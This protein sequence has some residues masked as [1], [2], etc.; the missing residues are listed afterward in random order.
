MSL[1]PAS[2]DG[3]GSSPTR[4]SPGAA[5][6]VDGAGRL[7]GVIT[8]ASELEC[9]P[10]D[11]NGDGTVD[12]RDIGC[13]PVGSALARLRPANLARVRDRARHRV[14]LQSC[15]PSAAPPCPGRHRHRRPR[16]PRSGLPPTEAKLDRIARACSSARRSRDWGWPRQSLSISV[17][18]RRHL[19]EPGGVPPFTRGRGRHFGSGRQCGIRHPGRDR[20]RRHHPARPEVCHRERPSFSSWVSSRGTGPRADLMVYSR[21]KGQTMTTDQA[22]SPVPPSPST[23]MATWTPPS[24]AADPSGMRSER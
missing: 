2:R 8:L 3:P 19:V 14:F 9:R 11:T 10:G 21:D 13:V 24:P 4:A 6:A 15:P 16:H 18:R 12:E 5:A 20:R 22:A 1:K 17:L 7:V 23:P